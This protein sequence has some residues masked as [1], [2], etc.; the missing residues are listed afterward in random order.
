MGK[1]PKVKAKRTLAP[2]P[3]SRLPKKITLSD[4]Q[5]SQLSEIKTKYASKLKDAVAKVGLT[6]EQKQARA[7]AI[8][9]AKAAG[10]KGKEVRVAANAAVKLTDDQKQARGEVVTLRKEIQTAIR[11]ILTD[12]QRALLKGGKK[13]KK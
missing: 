11:G 8:K 13:K 6:K 5:K 9:E 1:R 4:E 12:E 3:R 7:A 10:K 2:V